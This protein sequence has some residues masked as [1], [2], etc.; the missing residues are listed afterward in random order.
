MALSLVP[1]ALGQAG[2]RDLLHFK[3]SHLF[4]FYLGSR[5]PLVFFFSLLEQSLK[6]S[7]TERV[8]PWQS[9]AVRKGA[10]QSV[11]AVTLTGRGR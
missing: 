4:H 1:G 3:A 10:F 7:C 11:A 8:T 9:A 6:L 2:E 5:R